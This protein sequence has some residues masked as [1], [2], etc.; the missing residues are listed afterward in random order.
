[1]AAFF[2]MEITLGRVTNVFDR[3]A[4]AKTRYVI[5][6]GGT[7]SSKSYSIVQLL[8]LKAFLEPNK[9]TLI[10]R[11]TFPSVRLTTLVDFRRILFLSGLDKYVTES[12][13]EHNFY[14][15]SGSMVHF[16]SL[17]DP[18]KK[19]S[20]NWNYIFMD[21]LPDFTQD[22]FLTLKMYLSAPPGD[23]INQFFGAL[24]PIDE[25]SWIKTHILDSGAYDV[26]EIVS[27]YLDN[28]QNLDEATIQ[29]IKNLEKQDANFYRVY[30]LGLWGRLENL[31]YSNWD[32]LPVNHFP[33]YPDETVYG[34]D[35]G[36]NN[37]MA[38][39]RI[40]DKDKEIYERELI[41]ESRLTP[42]I[43][44]KRMDEVIPESHKKTK[45]VYCDSEA[46]DNI[47]MLLNAGYHAQPAKKG[48]GSVVEGITRVKMAGT[49]HICSDSINLIKEKQSYSWKVDKVTGKPIDEPVKFNDH[50]MDSERYALFSYLPY[51]ALKSQ[52]S[53]IYSAD[54]IEADW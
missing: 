43:L 1:M 17:D 36:F 24:N 22:D 46:A 47:Q 39:I 9:K 25:N 23:G 44:I 6:R 45:I 48:K 8:I 54:A 27:T 16:D 11:K 28:I 7:R 42:D 13:A 50:L 37:P 35:F 38:L 26:T 41:Y 3:N 2:I 40:D 14:F 4:D 19:K 12:K 10:L 53:S 20:S 33:E 18:L 30:T 29:E 49:I 15:P 34:L 52:R 21:E 51:L 5:N 32:I 31:I